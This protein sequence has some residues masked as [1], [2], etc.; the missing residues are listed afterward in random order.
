MAWDYQ[1]LQPRNEAIQIVLQVQVWR[2]RDRVPQE[3]QLEGPLS[4]AH[5]AEAL[6]VWNLQEVL[7]A[8]RQFRSPSEERAFDHKASD[9]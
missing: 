1:N 5:D 2:V 9:E 7:H 4:Q 3:L 8:E 6:P